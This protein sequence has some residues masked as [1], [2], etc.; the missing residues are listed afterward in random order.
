M[1]LSYRV[2]R[3]LGRWVGNAALLLPPD[4]G[5]AQWRRYI[6]KTRVN[7]ADWRLRAR[8]F[9]RAE[10]IVRP[11]LDNPQFAGHAWAVTARVREH[12]GD[13]IGALDAARRAT[14]EPVTLRALME[15]HRLAKA[16]R[17]QDEPEKLLPRI[18][19]EVARLQ[20]EQDRPERLMVFALIRC[21]AW[22]ELAK[23]LTDGS[24][25]GSGGTP[26]TQLPLN[27]LRR[28]A[29]RALSAGHTSA[30]VTMARIV[31]AAQPDDEAARQTF[32]DG[33]DQLNVIASGWA[34]PP[35]GSTP[36]QPLSTAVLSV[37]AQS[38]PITSG[39]YASRSHGLL[40][41]LAARGWQM[42]AVTRLGFPYDRWPEWD[43]RVVPE[44]D[45]VDGITY[46]R[47]LED[48]VRRYPQHPLRSYVDRFADQ[49]VQHAIRHEA[50]LLH[51]SSFYVT[52]LAS[53]NAARRLGLPFIYEMRGL[54]D[55]IRIS[56]NPSFAATDRYKF[57]TSL[58]N[59]ICHQADRVFVITEALR[60]EMAGRGVPEDRMVVLPNGVD[61]DRFAPRQRDVE[62]ERELGVAGKTLIG[63]A[64]GLVDYE[65]V[66]LLLEASAALRPRRDD[67][68][69]I[70]V[71]D[72]HYQNALLALVDRLRLG[73][74]ATFTG[75]VPHSEVGRYLSLFDIAP[76][77]R[78]PLPVCEM[79]SPIK[80][81]E[82]MAMGKAV[83]VSSVAALTEIVSD[84]R[85]GLVF[86][87]GDVMDLTRT[88]ERLLD[89][90]ELRT[91]LGTAARDWVRA[92]R[93]WSS[94]VEVV[95]TTYR[96]VLDRSQKAGSTQLA[97]KGLQHE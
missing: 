48:G 39:G 84:G 82:S 29:R 52:G 7:V 91:S 73:D 49:V 32:D 90:P 37:L 54:E 50:R 5:P 95:D 43:D 71:G 6:A 4:R 17:V 79:I 2:K 97:G 11:I 31:L 3:R 72:G 77:P 24:F 65:G 18:F 60:R 9:Y 19:A 93:D 62:L 33:T 15:H 35:A 8:D 10:R 86:A 36:Y 67:F 68:H 87:K 40:T 83:I 22:D 96:D 76:F 13:L 44:S 75:R 81:F 23:F 47:I 46:H 26:P 59:E 58:E 80:P 92:E 61:A 28:A 12:R 25:D 16:L 89:S 70:V 42:E 56:R 34:E 64:G 14:A 1:S 41:S 53:A 27:S 20:S 51:A 88:I 63:Y 57:L 55:L 69:L 21:R 94:I 66:D 78:L 45:T 85:T 30:A 74:V 38:V